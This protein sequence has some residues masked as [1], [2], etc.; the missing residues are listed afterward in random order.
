MQ[1][2][3][4]LDVASVIKRGTDL[5]KSTIREFFKYAILA[6]LVSEVITIYVAV[7]DTFF[8]GQR[9][10]Y[11]AGLIFLVL[12]YFPIIYYS[13]RVAITT[14]GKLRAI[15]EE[16]SFDFADQY[17]ISKD[18]FWRVF[19]VLIVRFILK[20]IMILSI[21]TPGASLLEEIINHT[22]S[23]SSLLILF[24]GLFVAALSL[25]GMIRLEFA[26]MVIYWDIDSRSTDL[27]T[28]V[29][30]TKH[31]FIEKLKII[32]LANIPSFI[33]GIITTFTF[34]IDFTSSMMPFKWFL[35][36]VS[37]GINVLFYSWSYSVYYPMLEQMKAF[38]LPTEKR[39]DKDG[40]E[41]QTF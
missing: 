11:I 21:V 36:A 2:E 29:L 16:R 26:S 13:V 20:I 41:W 7:F 12:L 5:Y 35:V 17:S 32:I 39:I 22:V 10:V 33:L 28:S 4:P 25:Y 37:M 1:Y 18:K 24:A 3:A 30:M 38:A 15:I 27:R 8:L 40:R 9:L 34:F 23:F 31:Q 6:V 19:L 14:I